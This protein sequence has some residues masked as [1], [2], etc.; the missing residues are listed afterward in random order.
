MPDM[1]TTAKVRFW[2]GKD[3]PKRR[4]K[5]DGHTDR[6]RATIEVVTL[7]TVPMMRNVRTNRE[8]A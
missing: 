4:I 7:G 2:V 3:P 6:E 1:L 5:L 8:M